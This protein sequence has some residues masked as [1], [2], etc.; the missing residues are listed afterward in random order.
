[1]TQKLLEVEAGWQGMAKN[2]HSQFVLYPLV[3]REPV[4]ISPCGVALH[5]RIFTWNRSVEQQHA[6]WLKSHDQPR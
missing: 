4:C 5:A 3:D 1:V 2:Q 6:T